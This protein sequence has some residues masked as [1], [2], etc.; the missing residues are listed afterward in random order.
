MKIGIIVAAHH[1]DKLRPNGEELINNFCKSVSCINHEFTA[2]IYDNASPIPINISYPNVKLIYVKDQTLRGLSGAWNSG[3]QLA[4]SEGCDIVI[5]SNDD[6]EINKSVNIFIEM[7]NNHK[8]N[9]IS[10]YG[11]VSNGVLSGVQKRNEP[12]DQIIE[13][14]GDK[15]NMVN[16][17]F[18]GFTKKF[19]HKFK[20]ENKNLFDED[21]FP[22]G[23][24]E[25][26]FQLRIWKKG[27]RS[28]VLGNCHIFHHK[29]RG[30][31]QLM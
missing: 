3:T 14:T 2:Y 19:Y 11:P 25:E 4:I 9:E 13:L 15:N 7:I 10:I 26:E 29:F 1:S 5:I 17:F 16:G 21:N 6:V 20:M 28:F 12:I 18:F 23:G 27:A 24:N 22:W 31:K 30:W 8:H